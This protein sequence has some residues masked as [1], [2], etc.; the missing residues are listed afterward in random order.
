MEVQQLSESM[1]DYQE[2]QVKKI[3]LTFDDFKF[4]LDRAIVKIQ[5][6]QASLETT[7]EELERKHE[8]I[9]EQMSTKDM[10]QKMYWEAT[11]EVQSRCKELEVKS[12]VMQRDLDFW[13]AKVNISHSEDFNLILFDAPEQNRWFTGREKEIENLEKFLP[14]NKSNGLKISAI[15]GLGGC[16]KSTLA[17]HFAWRHKLEYEGGVFWIS[18]EDE[19]KFESSVS[20][21]ALRLGIEANSFDLTLSK[22]LTWISKREKPWLLV[23]DDID[24]LNLSEQMHMVLSGRW[25]RQASGHV[26]L[27]TRREPKELCR[28][29]DLEPSCCVEAFAFSEE[30]AKRFLVTRCGAATTG[31]EVAL[32]ELVREL[33][34][35]PL[36]LEQAGAHIKALQCSISNYLEEYKIQRLTLLNH[37]PRAKPLWEYESKNRLAV[38]TTWLINF[39]YVRKSPQGELATRFLHAAA[40]FAPNE[41]QEKLINCE[42]FSSDHLSHQNDNFALLRNEIVEILTKFSLFQRKSC[43]SLGLHRLVQ[44][45][46]RNRMTIE[47]TASSLLKAVQLLHQSFRG[48]PSPD[49]ILVDITASDQKQPSASLTNPSLFYS[50][51]KLTRHASELQQ[52]LKALLGQQN[53]GREVKETVLTRET[54]RVIY[55]NAVQLSV[56]GHQADAKEAERFAY[57]IFDS[58]TSAGVALSTKDLTKT[59]SSYSTSSSNISKNCVVFKSA[60]S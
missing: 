14:L 24:Q 18:M 55:E 42:L 54:S 23:I 38:H 34:C 26:L 15:C 11:Q 41:I 28:L 43:S 7:C 29:V 47:E 20:D 44:E 4:E 40:F 32:D 35:L 22:F 60:S 13:A 30:E 12:S 58:C 2:E 33:G 1:D 21:L 53:I 9:R 3:R 45:V 31:K 16:G 50:W 8:M 46:I 10:E 51:S 17:T 48:S 39:E 25:K 37:N 19:R 57:Q 49:Q 59:I 5:E 6:K 52:H 56:R 36:A 27:T